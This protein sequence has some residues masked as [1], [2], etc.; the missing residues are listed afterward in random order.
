VATGIETCDFKKKTCS[1]TARHEHVGIVDFAPPSSVGVFS[2]HL[3]GNV[4][5]C[6][7]VGLVSLYGDHVTHSRGK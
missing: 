1:A 5:K 7:L 4:E 3:L 2:D 6:I